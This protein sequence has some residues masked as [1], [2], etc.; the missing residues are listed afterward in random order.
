MLPF[1]FSFEQFQHFLSHF[2][3]IVVEIY[4]VAGLIIILWKRLKDEVKK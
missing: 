2:S 1:E 3:L 4:G